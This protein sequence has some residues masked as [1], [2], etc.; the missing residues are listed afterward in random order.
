M[1]NM[2]QIW[3]QKTFRQSQSKMLLQGHYD[4]EHPHPQPVFLPSILQFLQYNPNGLYKSWSLLQGRRLNQ[5]H[6]MKWHTYMS[7]PMTQ[8]SIN[9]LQFMPSKIQPT[10]H[11]I[12][13]GHNSKVKG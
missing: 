12:D 2:P 3:K 7:H 8:L 5:D 9:F 10:P 13:Q 1:R 4:D 11:F 6:T